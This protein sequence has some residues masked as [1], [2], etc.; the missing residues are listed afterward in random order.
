MLAALCLAGLGCD[1]AFDATTLATSRNRDK[2]STPNFA[3]ARPGKIARLDSIP[4]VIHPSIPPLRNLDA[5]YLVETDAPATPAPPA[6]APSKPAPSTPP[7]GPPPVT[8]AAPAFPVRLKT[9]VALAQSLPTG[10]AMGFSVDY[11]FQHEQPR[12]DCRYDWI[13][14]NGKGEAVR[15]EAGRLRPQGTLQ[16]YVTIWKPEHGPFQCYFLETTSGSSRLL[17]NKIALD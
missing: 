13:I 14:V 2:N 12:V 4:G 16:T 6:P 17:S 9:G 3:P 8:A 10:T 5:R 15:I 11:Q 1:A 7:V